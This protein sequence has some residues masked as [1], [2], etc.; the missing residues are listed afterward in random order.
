MCSLSS[1]EFHIYAWSTD[2]SCINYIR[3]YVISYQSDFCV[4][5]CINIYLSFCSINDKVQHTLVD[6]VALH[7]KMTW[8]LAPVLQQILVLLVILKPCT[9]YSRM[10]AIC[11]IPGM[12]KYHLGMGTDV[13]YIVCIQL[14]M[15]TGVPYIVCIHFGMETGVFYIVCIHGRMTG[16]LNKAVRLFYIHC[17]LPIREDGFPDFFD[18][19]EQWISMFFQPELCFHSIFRG[20]GN[21][22]THTHQNS[23]LLQWKC[24]LSLDFQ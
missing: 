15:E 21:T 17:A 18:K 13:P 12:K 16:V 4:E 19:F 2:I 6:A 22:N 5:L 3:P 10:W 8:K 7:L 14:G 11:F 24:L 1:F 9:Y 23:R 20:G